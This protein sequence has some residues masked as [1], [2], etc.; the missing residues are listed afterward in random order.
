MCP[1]PGPEPKE[2]GI[3]LALRGPGSHPTSVAC[4]LC[5]SG[6]DPQSSMSPLISSVLLWNNEFVNNKLH[7][8]MSDGSMR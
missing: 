1:T 6:Q 4:L 7:K 3:H 5:D 2:E 8:R